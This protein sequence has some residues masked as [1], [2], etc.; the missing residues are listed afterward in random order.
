MMLAF[1]GPTVFE[2]P[3]SIWTRF[4]AKTRPESVSSLDVSLLDAL[5][6]FRMILLNRR[7]RKI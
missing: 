5:L 6:V 3:T 1:L 7:L 4:A 2:V